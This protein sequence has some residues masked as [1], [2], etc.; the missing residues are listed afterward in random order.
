VEVWPAGLVVAMDETSGAARSGICQLWC[1][2]LLSAEIAPFLMMVSQQLLLL[3]E[4]SLFSCLLLYR[5][6]AILL[7]C[8]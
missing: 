3:N 2:F 5:I 1:G 4:S 6:P 8:Y 7:A